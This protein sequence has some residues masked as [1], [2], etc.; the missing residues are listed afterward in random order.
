MQLSPKISFCAPV[1]A[2][3][4]LAVEYNVQGE[5]IF[6]GTVKKSRGEHLTPT[7]ETLMEFAN[8]KADVAAI[9]RFIRKH[10]PPLELYEKDG[11]LRF[12]FLLGRW[13][14]LQ[15]QFQMAWDGIIGLVGE[16]EPFRSFGGP[17]KPW[18][19]V[20]LN[21]V[22]EMGREGAIYL[23]DDLYG[24]M[25]PLLLSIH[26]SAR[27]C[28]N[29]GCKVTPYFIA[30]HKRQEYCSGPCAAWGQRQA[31]LKWWADSGPEWQRGKR[32][33]AKKKPSKEKKHGTHKAR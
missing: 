20:Q 17:L 22:F 24:A 7:A 1:V 26:E 9:E 27:H 30:T 4:Q 23:A 28:K 8:C 16:H 31:K 32:T 3:T 10:G 2:V 19:R 11:A 14:G 5:P 21:G 18:R 33:A 15:N 13:S 12:D 6:R 29:P 25:L